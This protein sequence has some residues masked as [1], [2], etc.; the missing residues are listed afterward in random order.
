M[1]FKALCM[2]PARCGHM[3]APSTP[4][5]KSRRLG[6]P[7]SSLSLIRF[8][9]PDSHR[10]E[11]IKPYKQELIYFLILLFFCCPTIIIVAAKKLKAAAAQAAECPLNAK[12]PNRLLRHKTQNYY[13]YKITPP[14]FDL[15]IKPFRQRR[16][17]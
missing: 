13:F 15:S 7:Y 2:F 10:I 4:A 1:L 11:R 9:Y 16:I 14:N 5:D 12:T 17:E 8:T 6:S 3:L